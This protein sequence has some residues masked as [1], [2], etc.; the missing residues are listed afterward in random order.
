MWRLHLVLVDDDDLEWRKGRKEG[1]KKKGNGGSVFLRESSLTPVM[2]TIWPSLAFLRSDWGWWPTKLSRDC[3]PHQEFQAKRA[4]TSPSKTPTTTKTTTLLAASRTKAPIAN[5]MTNSEKMLHR[6]N[7]GMLFMKEKLFT[8]L[9]LLT[10]SLLLLLGTDPAATAP[11]FCPNPWVLSKL[12]PG[13]VKSV[14]EEF[15]GDGEAAVA[16]VVVAE[17]WDSFCSWVVPLPNTTTFAFLPLP[18]A[19]KPV[20]RPV[21]ARDGDCDPV[22]PRA[23]M[24]GVVLL[25]WLWLRLWLLLLLQWMMV[26][27]VN[28]LLMCAV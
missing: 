16:V 28:V 18:E 3:L 14:R 5:K 7:L 25:L 1:R 10:D 22:M 23:G 26:G 27:E 11:W 9:K 6:I 20:I 24:K 4:Q 13:L 2:H 19:A 21:A 15:P 17:V 12:A 8:R